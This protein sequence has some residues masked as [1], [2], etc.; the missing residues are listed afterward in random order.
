MVIHF[1]FVRKKLT[2]TTR[3]SGSV[4]DSLVRILAKFT[5]IYF[6]DDAAQSTAQIYVW[7]RYDRMFAGDI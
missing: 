4:S 3:C 6:V 5:Q 1:I 2:G 7:L